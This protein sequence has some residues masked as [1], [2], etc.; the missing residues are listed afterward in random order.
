MQATEIP[1]LI[2]GGGAAGTMLSLELARHGVD[3]RTVDRLAGPATTSKAITIH[4]RMAEIF[5]RIDPRIAERCVNRAIHNKGYVLH[6]V[7][8]AGQRRE[9]RPGI[10]FTGLESKYPYILVHS[11]SETEQVLRDYLREEYG[12]E[13]HWGVQCT[14]VEH[15]ED[16]V[17][18]T[19]EHADGR[20]E[21]VTSR[22]LVACD[23]MNSRIR[24][25]LGLIQD[26]SD[27]AGTK[28]QNLDAVLD[29]FPDVEDYV[30][31]CAGTDHFIMIVKLPGGYFR[32]LLSDRGEAAAPNT[33]PERA[34]MKL[35][36]Q[37]FDGVRLGK[38]IWHSRWES[39]VR[40]AQTYRERNVFLAGDSAHVHSTTGGQGMN[41][42]MQDA[43]NLGWK[44]GLV[45]RGLASA[46]LLDTYERE[47]RPVA[48]QVIWAASSLH[49][50][51][52]GHGK[53]IEQ[54]AQRV[55]DK[56]FLDAVVGRC[57]GLSYSYRDALAGDGDV[58]L[59]GPSAGDRSTAIDFDSDTGILAP[60]SPSGYLL[61][62]IADGGNAREEVATVIARISQR[63]PGVVD[64][65]VCE[66][67]EAF[68]RRCGPGAQ[69]VLVRPDGYIGARCRIDSAAALS[70][71]LAA[72]LGS[73]GPG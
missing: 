11:Q 2:V 71:K 30:H 73:S 8:E 72:E 13:T 32:L 40:L 28:M 43:W 10:D 6:F 64:T 37:H 14:G 46:S 4:A 57:S 3:A 49:E 54:R 59:P 58:E 38:T 23:G 56:S 5:E 20:T 31:Y 60:E 1:V 69:L 66:S 24:H 7:N 22:Y 52:M 50:I 34:F 16:G 45:L 48:E 21:L 18:A 12:R 51:F 65:R 61:A 42:C 70:R 41:C 19:L 55:G 9:V 35:V 62:G 26:E 47:R 36:D 29:D 67:D 25:S 53:G 27:Y 15:V 63:F 39:W 44:L 68:R 17:L 33:T